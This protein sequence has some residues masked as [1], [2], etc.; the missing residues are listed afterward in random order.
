MF[1]IRT[2]TDATTPANK[3]L[4]G[5]IQAIIRDQFPDMPARD[6]EKLPD[7]VA[8]PF[9]HEFLTRIY[10]AENGKGKMDGFAVV[11]IEPEMNFAYLE[12][13][14][15]AKGATSGI[16]AALYGTVRE[17]AVDKG[18]GGIYFECLPD[19]IELSPTVS[20][21]KQNAAR[22]K[23]YETFGAYPITGTLYETPVTPGTYD[24]PY[25]VFDGLDRHALPKAETVRKVVEAILERKY[26]HLC[27][28]EYIA[29]VLASIDDA[30]LD[31]RVARYQQSAK[32]GVGITSRIPLVMNE[33]HDIHH[34]REKGYVE[35][36]ARISAIRAALDLSDR[37][38][39]V[40]PK[41]FD[42]KHIKAVHDPRLVEY[43]QTACAE[44][45]LEKSI[46]PY[47]FP[48]RNANRMPKD[49]SVLAGYWC[50]D[51]FT[52]INRN[53]YP[54]ARG[55]VDCAL[56]AAEL[57][58]KGALAAY[59]LV[60]PPGHH[61]ERRTFGGFCY[62]NN[63]GVAANYL[64]KYGRVAMLDIDYH[65]GNGTQDLFYDRADILT[66]SIHG[67]P[68]FAYPYFTGFRDETGRGAGAGYNLNIPL[69]EKITPEEHRASLSKALARVKKHDPAFLI[70]ALGLDTA[71]GDPTGTWANRPSDFTKLGEMISALGLPTVYVQEG[72]Y[73]IRSLGGNAR[74]FFEGVIKNLE[75]VKPFADSTS[76]PPAPL[77]KGMIEWRESVQLTDASA[78]RN[79]VTKVDVFSPDEISIAEELVTERITKG[80][81]SG[82]D[83]FFAEDSDGL[84]GYSCYGSTPGTINS[85]DLYWIVLDPRARGTGLAGDILNRTEKAIQAKGGRYLT[86]ETSSTPGYQAARR[87]YA[88]NGFV[89]LVEIENFY[90]PG[91][92]KLIFR[93][94][95]SDGTEI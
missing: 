67:D 42:I 49:R 88:S 52:P 79:L 30:T 33:A 10:V 95:L 53:A 82:Y 34:I 8:N 58:Y 75:G 40:V 86:A 90:R 76:P 51:T 94:D 78:V 6:I 74:H 45:P 59:A 47:V 19:E 9:A 91:D 68:A 2:L 5:E 48:V 71:K 3:R 72:G 55:A 70:I 83:F 56:T 35:A 27:P 50:I 26:G 4:I 12:L 46:Y 1:R 25:L 23:F 14:S 7:Q 18:L 54:A 31:L 17:L 64:S 38:E 61:A 66:V 92:H 44:A 81:S 57:V 80:R 60:R 69:P 43:I 21:R 13:V 37:F 24:S 32:P 85:F 73:R 77:F 62:F 65:H 63:A 84:M 11:M 28:P 87:F 16:G 41:S 89:L 20:I 15:T 36:P 93:K 39:L 29:K 22:L